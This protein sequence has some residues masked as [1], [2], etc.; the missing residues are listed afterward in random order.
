MIF[1][2]KIQLEALY[3]IW[4]NDALGDFIE[5]KVLFLK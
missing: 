3:A 1:P 4:N 5:I 2:K